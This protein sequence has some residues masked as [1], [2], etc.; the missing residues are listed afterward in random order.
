MPITIT[1]NAPRPQDFE[2]NTSINGDSRIENIRQ[3]Q[4][5]SSTSSK[6]SPVSSFLHGLC[7]NVGSLEEQWH[8]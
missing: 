4:E 8:V 5:I 1:F 6:S 7:S 2:D 3:T